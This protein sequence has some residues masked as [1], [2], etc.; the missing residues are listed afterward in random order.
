MLSGSMEKGSIH[1]ST[2]GA[3]VIEIVDENLKAGF[4]Q[5]PR[6]VLRAKELSF[7]AKLLYVALLDYAWE[8]GSCFPGHDKLAKDL[9]TSHDTGRRAL[10][11]LRDY[12]LIR[13]KQQG[14]NKPNVYYLSFGHRTATGESLPQARIRR[15]VRYLT[16]VF[17]QAY[18]GAQVMRHGGA[19]RMLGGATVSE[20]ATT[21]V[22]Y[23]PAI[24][25]HLPYLVQAAARVC[26][27]LEQ[28]TVWLLIEKVPGSAR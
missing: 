15:P 26:R 10:A 24:E 4:A 2:S 21:T 27:F 25:N 28:E 1:Q 16:H 18:R 8:R 11:E 20:A 6:P 12:G 5:L 17:C 13:W 7:R 9:D 14:L 22:A 3:D 19:Y 23:G